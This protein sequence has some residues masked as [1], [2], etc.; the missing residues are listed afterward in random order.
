LLRVDRAIGSTRAG[1]RSAIRGLDFL[2][3]N[4]ACRLL[5]DIVAQLGKPLLC[6][7]H[8]GCDFA[9]PCIVGLIPSGPNT[10]GQVIRIAGPSGKDGIERCS[11]RRLVLGRAHVKGLPE[12]RVIP[13]AQLKRRHLGIAAQGL[14][15]SRSNAGD[16][17]AV[18]N[19]ILKPRRQR[20]WTA[21]RLPQ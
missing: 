13:D 8:R 14:R 5:V 18:G 19:G 21:A 2:A 17:G 10:R 9:P 4:L 7:L 20:F 1:L 16:G 12:S 3:D 11:P 6:P 15:C